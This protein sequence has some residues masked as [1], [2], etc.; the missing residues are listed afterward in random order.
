MSLCVWRIVISGRHT[1]TFWWTSFVGTAAA[2][3]SRYIPKEWWPPPP[4]PR[5]CQIKKLSLVLRWPQTFSFSSGR[6]FI[7]D[8][9]GPRCLL[10]S[11]RCKKRLDFW[12]S[13]G[14]PRMF[15][16]VRWWEI[17]KQYN[18]CIIASSIPSSVLTNCCENKNLYLKLKFFFF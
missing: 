5:S 18:Y 1:N 6:I 14:R 12:I 3:D 10:F 2:K 11:R 17:G 15:L 13:N 9:K 7:W 8:P 16:S 4:A